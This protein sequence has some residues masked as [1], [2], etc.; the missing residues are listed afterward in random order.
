MI[1]EA[2]VQEQDDRLR[3]YRL[4]AGAVSTGQ[5]DS[6][7]EE[8]QD[9]F[10]PLPGPALNLLLIKKIRLLSVDRPFKAVEV[11]CE[12]ATLWLRNK[13]NPMVVSLVRSYG[14][15]LT[16]KNVSF[17]VI[18]NRVDQVGFRVKTKSLFLALKAV[19]YL[20]ESPSVS[21]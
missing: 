21:L 3:F 18:N 9:R 8:I 17:S 10:G 19:E 14:A 4:L 12:G 15:A 13:K 20:F 7:T 2:F 16:E 5:I 6:L 1:P 11:D